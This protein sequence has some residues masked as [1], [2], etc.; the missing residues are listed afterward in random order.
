MGQ[1]CWGRQSR[2]DGK[3]SRGSLGCLAN[4]LNCRLQPP[5]SHSALLQI[6]DLMGDKCVFLEKRK[7][8]GQISLRNT[9]SR[10]DDSP[11]SR[12]QAVFPHDYRSLLPQHAERIGDSP[13][14]LEQTRDVYRC[15]RNITLV[16][17]SGSN[18]RRVD[19]G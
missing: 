2:K 10:E 12:V 16:A 19:W 4:L 5:A 8:C 15:S 14:G 1:F 3:V 11:G 17:T 9:S 7:F 13:W 18:W 6:L